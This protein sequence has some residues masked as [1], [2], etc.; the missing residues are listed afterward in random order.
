MS[1]LPQALQK[2]LNQHK[3]NW[4]IDNDELARRCAM[5]N[6]TYT[7][8]LPALGDNNTHAIVLLSF[9][10]ITDAIKSART[11]YK[12]YSLKEEYIRVRSG[13][14]RIAFE[15]PLSQ[16][17]EEIEQIEKQVKAQYQSELDAIKQQYIDNLTSEL[18]AEKQAAESMKSAEEE[19]QL[20]KALLD[21][22]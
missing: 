19:E 8:A 5:A 11:T 13:V 2:R 7:Q 3:A 18:L 6:L 22:I 14:Y 21:L 20:K 15:K 12:D 9:N 16:Q 17:D 1:K 10:T 4:T